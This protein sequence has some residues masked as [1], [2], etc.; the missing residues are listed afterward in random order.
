[1]KGWIWTATRTSS[2]TAWSSGSRPSMA[3]SG[4]STG[5]SCRRST[6][7]ALRR[8]ALRKVAA[9]LRMIDVPDTSIEMHST[10][11]HPE[12]MPFLR[13]TPGDYASL[14]Q[15]ARLVDA[16]GRYREH[17]LYNVDLRLDQRYFL[18]HGIFPMG[19]LEVGTTYRMLDSQDRVD[20][21]R[22]RSDD[23]GAEG[24]RARLPGHPG[25]GR[26]DRERVVRRR[27]PRR[28][29]GRHPGG[30]AVARS[31]TRSGRHLFRGR[32]RVLHGVPD[33]EGGGARHHARTSAGRRASARPRRRASS[34]TAASCTSRRR[35]SCA[36]GST[37]TRTGSITYTQE[38]HL[39]PDR[40]R[41]AQPDPGA[42]PG[43]P[44]A[45]QRHQRHADQSGG[46]GRTSGAVEEEPARGLQDRRGAAP[47]R[48]R[49]LHLRAEGRAYTNAS[50]RSTSPRSIR[51]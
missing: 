34:P 17:E 49:R 13:V 18:K 42:G 32:G 38:R 51:A 7:A 41:P 39:R 27:A 33:Q 35:T 6:S 48:P 16:W 23:G 11:M 26:R 44:V 45:R 9:D 10:L 46:A 30:A 22:A 14:G 8:R 47:L 31:R 43:P 19:L 40:Y 28:N 2:A 29:G 4:W 1:M 21:P 25:A 24:E 20:L 15:T 50:P 37:W 3:S 5:T 36:A 12:P